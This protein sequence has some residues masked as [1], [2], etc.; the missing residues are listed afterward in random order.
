MRRSLILVLLLAFAGFSATAAGRVQWTTEESQEW[1][2]RTEWPLGC[3][4]TLPAG[5]ALPDS[6][7]ADLEKCSSLGCN[8]VRLVIE[9]PGADAAKLRKLLSK[10]LA[11]IKPFKFRAAVALYPGEGLSEADFQAFCKSASSLVSA[12]RNEAAILYWNILPCPEKTLSAFWEIPSP[13]SSLFSAVRAAGPS[14]PLCA[15]VVCPFVADWK[16]FGRMDIFSSVCLESDIIAFKSAGPYPELMEYQK[17]LAV[18]RRPVI[19]EEFINH[20]VEAT[21]DRLLPQ[22]KTEK[23]GALFNLCDVWPDGEHP[24]SLAEPDMI[25]RVAMFKDKAGKGASWQKTGWGISAPDPSRVKQWSETKA[26]DWWAQQEW[27]VGCMM[28]PR[29]SRNQYGVW[30]ASTFDP[31]LLTTEFNICKRLGFNVVR[32]YLHEDMWF[33]DAKGFKERINEVLDIAYSRGIRITFT[34]CTN[35]G[36]SRPTPDG[37]QPASAGWVQSPKDPIF[38]DQSQ[39][40][41]FKEYIQDILRTFAHDERIFY[42]LLWNEP[43]NLMTAQGRKSGYG[44]RDVMKIMSQMYEWAWEVRPDQPLASSPWFPFNPN[45]T[46]RIR[47]DVE[48]FAVRYSDIVVFHSYRPPQMLE[49]YIS[50]LSRMRRPMVCEEYMARDLGSY[51]DLYMPVLKRE[52][53]AAINWGLVHSLSPGELPDAIWRHG[54]FYNDFVTPFNQAEVDYIRNF[55]SDKSG[56]GTAPKYPIYK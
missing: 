43:E 40:P 11:A 34:F 32:M 7:P 18:F 35:G 25:A 3:N 51:F 15:T 5:D 41:R 56:A 28:T 8:T 23:T 20:D 46:S 44:P 33:Q 54:I 30:Q 24:Y 55:L 1:W 49:N 26:R 45:G 14:Q 4:L 47:Y 9:C 21:F 22:L 50:C 37:V 19:C 53:V 13:V 12:F 38:F 42:W 39:W 6:F 48:A 16:A 10:A 52:K 36:S 17:T 27:P 29:G 2:A 31:A